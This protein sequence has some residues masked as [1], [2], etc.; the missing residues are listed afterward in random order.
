M[1]AE[2]ARNLHACLGDRVAQIS[3]AAQAV[4][5]RGDRCTAAE[6][7]AALDARDEASRVLAPLSA[8]ADLVLTPSALGVAPQGLAFTGDPVMCRPWTLLGLPAAN[9]PACRR[10]DGLPIGVQVV[11]AG[12]DDLSYLTYLALVEAALT[13]K[14]D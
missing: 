5:E 4:V 10:P 13:H 7:L 6:Y 12:R 14:E 9:V 1:A 11:G 8:A 3:E 2:T